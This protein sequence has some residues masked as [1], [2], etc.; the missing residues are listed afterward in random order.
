MPQRKQRKRNNRG[1]PNGAA[2]SSKGGQPRMSGPPAG[3]TSYNGPIMIRGGSRDSSMVLARLS[4]TGIISSNNI[5]VIAQVFTNIASNLQEWSS[6][7]S[8]YEEYRVLSFVVHWEPWYTNWVPI[9]VGT[10]LA[11]SPIMAYTDRNTGA[12]VISSYDAGYQHD[13]AVVRNIS[14]R[15]TYSVRAAAVSEMT[16]QVTGSPANTF[17][18]GIY[19]DTLTASTAYGLLCVE[20]LV[21]FRNR[22]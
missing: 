8:I 13:T 12:P 22:A 1:R 21:Q 5:G 19:S 6:W 4:D 14:Q 10:G 11:S 17:Q 2:R 9:T 16:F 15:W 20:A 3:A 7:A 18:I